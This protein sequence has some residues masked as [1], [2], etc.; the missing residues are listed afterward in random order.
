MTRKCFIILLLSSGLTVVFPSKVL[1]ST[2]AAGC[3]T[4]SG[5]SQLCPRNAQPI[6]AAASL[7]GDTLGV[8][9]NGSVW[10]LSSGPL[11]GLSERHITAQVV[12]LSP[13]GRHPFTPSY[14]VVDRT[15]TVF[16]FDIG[17]YGSI[18]H[19]QPHGPVTGIASSDDGRG[20][21][22]VTRS[23]EVYNFGDARNFGSLHHSIHQ[24]IV[25]IVP[26]NEGY[27]L[28]GANGGVHPFGSAVDRGS[29]NARSYAA[30]HRPRIVGAA[31]DESGNGYWLFG[32]NGSVFAFGDAPFLGS[33]TNQLSSPVVSGTPKDYPYLPPAS[34]NVGYCIQTY[35]AQQYCAA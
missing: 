32:R 4:F 12:A 28:V 10:S 15:G 21:L 8:T 13:A 31:V 35:S 29:L 20:Y 2:F 27:W 17:Y 30:A 3:V 26:T 23:G 19:G 16:A 18:P 7:G 34:G 1:A 11:P 9:K 14:W 22:V 6:V 24:E 25:T 33:W 5:S